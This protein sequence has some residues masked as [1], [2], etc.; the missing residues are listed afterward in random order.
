MIE[1]DLILFNGTV[2]TVDPEKPWAE[3]VAISGGNILTLGS[4][5][6]IQK[7]TGPATKSVDLH[8]AFVLPGFIDSHTHFLFGGFSL[9]NVQLSAVKTKEEFTAKIKDKSDSLGRG[10]W[11][12]NGDWDHQKFDPPLLPNKN[13]IDSVT[14]DNPVFIK[15][16]ID[17]A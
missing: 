14:P 12:L 4:S 11:I 2:W 7:L 3:A 5:K 6:T 13:W 16:G 1:A 15:F 9:S 8:G 10:A 17:L